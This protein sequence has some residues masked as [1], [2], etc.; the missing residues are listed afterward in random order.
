MRAHGRGSRRR[1]DVASLFLLLVG[2]VG[3]AFSYWLVTA[4]HFNVLVIVPS[5]ASVT[6]SAAHLTKREAPRK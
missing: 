6:L 3:G 2:L 1:L 5:I 4:E